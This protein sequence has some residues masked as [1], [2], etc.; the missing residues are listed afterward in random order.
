[1]RCKVCNTRL[2]L[3]MQVR[4]TCRCDVSTSFC[5]KHIH[6]HMCPYDYKHQQVEYL[7]KTC[8]KVIKSKI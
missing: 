8:V 3:A 4:G 5:S 7:Q 2:T 6:D 1:M